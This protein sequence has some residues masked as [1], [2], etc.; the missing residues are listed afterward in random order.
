MLPM[1]GRHMSIRRGERRPV[2]RRTASAGP[3]SASISVRSTQLPRLAVGLHI[4]CILVHG[5]NIAPCARR[6]GHGF[7]NFDNYRLRLLQH[8]GITWHHQTPTPLRGR[9]PRLAA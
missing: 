3:G 1:S 8:C 7:R 2:S 9:L 6:V 5:Y 4:F